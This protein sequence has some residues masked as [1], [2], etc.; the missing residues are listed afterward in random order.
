MADE[1]QTTGAAPGG[2]AST[3][4]AA[5]ASS[6]ATDTGQAAALGRLQALKSDSGWRDRFA[7]GEKG[8]VDEFNKLTDEAVLGDQAGK[9]TAHEVEQQ[10]L[11]SDVP[12][13]AH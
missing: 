1:Q 2:V 11:Q 3:V 7:A 6:E 8:A 4:G 5:I 12:K 13:A 10:Q 9:P